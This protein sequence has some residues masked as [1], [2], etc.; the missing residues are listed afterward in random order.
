[1]AAV[2]LHPPQLLPASTL[3]YPM[4]FSSNLVLAAPASGPTSTPGSCVYKCTGA[5]AVITALECVNVLTGVPVLVP[6]TA[7]GKRSVIK[8]RDVEYCCNPDAELLDAATCVDV[9][10]GSSITIPISLFVPS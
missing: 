5:G 1:M 7:G 4:Q 10:S 2:K 6:I 3:L 8:A 9:A